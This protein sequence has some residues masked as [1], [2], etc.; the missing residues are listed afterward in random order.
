[1]SNKITEADIASVPD[2]TD[3]PPSDVAPGLRELDEALR[4]AICGDLF[5]AP[6]TVTCGHCFCSL[7]GLF[8]VISKNTNL[9]IPW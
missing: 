8:L 7:V 3:F 2:P 1:M 9:K 5:E 6:L 4:C